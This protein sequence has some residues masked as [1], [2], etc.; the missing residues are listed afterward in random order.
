MDRNFTVRSYPNWI[1]DLS[2]CYF[3]SQV[4]SGQRRKSVPTALSSEQKDE[5]YQQLVREQAARSRKLDL[6]QRRSEEQVQRRLQDMKQRRQGAATH[7]IT[8]AAKQ[9]TVLEASKQVSVTNIQASK[10]VYKMT[11]VESIKYI[12][13][14]FKQY[15]S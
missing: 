15:L 8:T 6:E 10:R 11:S 1:F 9:K 4:G 12:G 7:I 13:G 3:H 2:C 14:L 5:L